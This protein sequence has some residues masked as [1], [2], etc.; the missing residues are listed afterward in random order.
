MVYIKLR[1]GSRVIRKG[2]TPFEPVLSQRQ[3]DR[4]RI[5]EWSI[6]F[7]VRG[8]NLSVLRPLNEDTLAYLDRRVVGSFMT[9]TSVMSPYL[10]KYS[11][12]LSVII[13]RRCF[14]FRNSFLFL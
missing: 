6:N 7:D 2:R 14:I 5:R 13:K 4:N 9:M 8:G 11:L 1:R 3:R 12:R 10:V